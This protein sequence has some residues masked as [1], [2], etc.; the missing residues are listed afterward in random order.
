LQ[1]GGAIDQVTTLANRIAA[2][3]TDDS[4]DDSIDVGKLLD[5]LRQAGTTDQVA[6]LVGLD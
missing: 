1:E 2:Y 6:T 4:I 5:G 3:T